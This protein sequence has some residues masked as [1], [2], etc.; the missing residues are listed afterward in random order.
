[1]LNN[2]FLFSCHSSLIIDMT[3]LEQSFLRSAITEVLPDLPEMIK[4][5][6]EEHLQS[7]GVETCDDF[8]F[9]EEADLLSALRPIQA[10]KVV[11]VLKQRWK[12]SITTSSSSDASPGPP[13]SLQSLSPGSSTPTSSNSS[14]SPHV[15]WVDTFVIPWDKFP[16]ELTQTLEREKRSSPRIRRE[17]VRLVFHKM[18]QKSSCISRKI[19][20]KSIEVAKKMV[21]NIL[22]LCKTS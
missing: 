18:S 4:D 7:L 21:S 10:R 3:D 22:N 14:Q 20:G 2:L 11:A 15:D 17:M 8:Q 9:I 13:P 12:S 6:L 5:I 1:M 16:E 19:G